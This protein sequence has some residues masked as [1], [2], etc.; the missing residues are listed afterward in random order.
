MITSIIVQSLLFIPL[1]MGILLSYRLLK[2][3]DLTVDGSFVL[4]AAVYARIFVETQS[5]LI[6]LCGAI[7]AG[8]CAGAVVAFIQFGDR[9]RPLIA[10]I[11]ML[12]MLYS[13]NLIIM[14]R[15]NIGLMSA[16]H[17]SLP[18]MLI[19]GSVC[20]IV[21]LLYG[22]L[23]T[24]VGLHFRAFGMNKNLLKRLGYSAEGYRFLG[25]ILSNMLAAFSGILTAQHNLY[26]DINMGFGVA[27]TGIGAVVIGQ[28]FFAH[29]SADN[30]STL[31]TLASGILGVVIYFLLLNVLLYYDVDPLYLKLAL[32]SILVLFMGT[33]GMKKG[34]V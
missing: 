6:S 18:L 2:I 11:L 4:G 32:G 8:G 17:V 20:G 5:M 1:V 21:L 34:G 28:Q 3:T 9:I 16:G 14:G 26:A 30:F 13:V 10:S 7:V 27:L 33:V 23:R 22:L 29:K 25:L 31:Y 12:F 19:L 24:P 15:P